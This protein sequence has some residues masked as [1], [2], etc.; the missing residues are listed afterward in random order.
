MNGSLRRRLFVWL[1]VAIV[2]VSAAM[3]AVS[4]MLAW[5]DASEVSDAQLRQVSASLATQQTVAPMS[6][7]TFK[8]G[9]DAEAHYVVRELGSEGLDA[10]P[11]ADVLLPLSLPIGLQT[12][13]SRGVQWRVMVSR[14]AGGQI[15]GVAQRLRARDE[16]ARDAAVLTLVPMLVLVPLLLLIV[17]RLLRQGFAP[18]VALTDKV[19]Q[20]DGS[21][22]AELDPT[23]I[24]LE[25]APLV[26]AVNRL[27]YRLGLVLAQQQRMVADAAHELRTPVAAIR[28]QADNLAHADLSPEARQR[29][30]SLQLGLGRISELIEQLLR[31]ARVQGAAQISSKPIALDNVVRTAIEETLTLAQGHGV[32]LG[33]IRLDA[34]QIHGDPTPAYALVRN[35]IDN[36][37]RYTPPGGAVDV[38]VEVHAGF[39]QLIVEDMGPGIE[40]AQRE[41]VFEPF[42]RILGT[43]QTGSGLGLAIV[44][45]AAQA[46]AGR[47]ELG[48]RGDGRSGLRVTYRQNI[49]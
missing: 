22:L 26:H 14:N 35:V 3:A 28:I 27:L 11:H 41:R 29:L 42:F 43:Q 32:D 16:S 47:V 36:A 1:S 7:A 13:E 15:F 31:L 17:H 9:E 4:F 12:L 24:P 38:S 40:P 33:C 5:R 25:A 21:R 34:A 44:R 10:D 6:H 23:G 39:V 30:Q 8:D 18:L 46:L 49:A 45:S 2:L 20:V 19:D 37:V 48:A